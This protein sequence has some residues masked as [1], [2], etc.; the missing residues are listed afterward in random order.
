MSIPQI[1]IDD[2]LL[3]NGSWRKVIGKPVVLTDDT[4]VVHTIALEFLISATT[5]TEMDSRWRSTWSA[6]TLQSPRCKL[7][8]DDDESN[9]TEDWF[10]GDTKHVEIVSAVSRMPDQPETSLKLH[11]VLTVTGITQ[12]PL[13]T[14]SANDDSIQ[15]LTSELK[16]A[17]SYMNNERFT[18]SAEGSFTSTIDE[19]AYG[20]F[21]LSSVTDSGSGRA[22][23][24]MSGSPTLPTFVPGMLIDVTGTTNYNGIHQVT[25]I[26]DASD[27]I[28]TRTAYGSDETGLSGTVAIDDYVSAETN[29]EN[30]INAILAV[31]GVAAGGAPDTTNELAL[32]SRQVTYE[33][34]RLDSL[35]FLLSA[36]PEALVTSIVD[37]AA[38][39]VQ[40]GLQYVVAVNEP[41]MWDDSLVSSPID[42]QI[43]GNVTIH[44]DA[45]DE[46]S[47]KAWWGQFR[48]AIREQVATDL[49]SGELRERHADYTLDYV[50]HEVGFNIVCTGNYNGT[51]AYSKRTSYG[52]EVRYSA[53]QDTDGFDHIQVP[54]GAPVK[55]ATQQISWLGEGA[56]PEPAPPQAEPGFTYFGPIAKTLVSSEP[57]VTQAG[58]RYTQE[59][60][61]Y[62]YLRL[63]LRQVGSP[64]AINPIT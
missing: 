61:E 14:S 13:S 64:P 38:A 52:E 5:S 33:S 1:Q 36:A 43:Q 4:G 45:I 56:L 62:R 10:I 20:P 57:M 53:W 22:R 46:Q 51:L 29:F 26:S 49:A 31:M 50:T 54:K 25:A 63:K 32:I 40:R 18:I 16:I 44:K 42:V 24:T 60:W 21:V 27:Y 48:A 35:S 19:D 37:S 7:W 9:P 59:E 34:D 30:G 3:D 11:C 8:F 28:D 41:D 2:T 23:F 55:I 12:I 6:F 47:L 58:D 39:R 17:K 15:G